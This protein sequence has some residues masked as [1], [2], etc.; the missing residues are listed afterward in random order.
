[1][2]DKGAL[3]IAGEGQTFVLVRATELTRLGLQGRI[4][5]WSFKGAQ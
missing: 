4:A 2:Q 5:K 1:M 3:K